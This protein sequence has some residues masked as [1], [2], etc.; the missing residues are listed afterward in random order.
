MPPP[1]KYSPVVALQAK[2]AH[3]KSS[4]APVLVKGVKKQ[5]VV[6]CCW[7][8]CV[9]VLCYSAQH[10]CKNFVSSD[11][12]TSDL[13][14]LSAWCSHR[15]NCPPLGALKTGVQKFTFPQQPHFIRVT[16]ITLLQILMFDL[17]FCAGSMIS[18]FHVINTMF[19]VCMRPLM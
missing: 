10:V 7:S 12:F 8:S 1:S 15:Q 6:L 18:C 14:Y 5:N 19:R 4:T 13:S 11:Q 2:N 16:E 17:T 3:K 9:S